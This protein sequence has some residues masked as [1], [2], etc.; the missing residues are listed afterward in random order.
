MRFVVG[1]LCTDM[2]VRWL[3]APTIQAQPWSRFHT[4]SL[5]MRRLRACLHVYFLL[6]GVH[7]TSKSVAHGVGQVAF[8]LPTPQAAVII[9]S[10]R[11][12]RG[13]V[14]RHTIHAYL[15]LCND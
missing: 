12:M 3:V 9:G 6:L 2:C 13:V 7:G 11:V 14:V 10:K 4:C 5:Y 8:W 15:M 1:L